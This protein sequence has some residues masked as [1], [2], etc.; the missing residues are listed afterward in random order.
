MRTI[1]F[2]IGPVLVLT[3]ACGKD[4]DRPID[5]S[6]SRD[7]SLAGQQYQPQQYVSPAE[8]AYGG[9]AP[10]YAPAAYGQP[11]RTAPVVRRPAARTTS[12]ASSGTVYSGTSSGRVIEEKH[13]KR[14][15]AI[16]A[17]AG[18]V[19]GATTSRDKLKGAIIG[20]AAGAILGGVIGNNVDITRKRVPQ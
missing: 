16:G 1:K 13:T 17:A 3:M 5:E 7:L 14:D 19:I 4:N 6:L 9:Y 20:G 11:Q 15:A 12:T 18:A 8:Q 2:M 10:Q